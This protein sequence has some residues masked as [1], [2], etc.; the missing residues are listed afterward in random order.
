M[1]YVFDKFL[2]KE[3]KKLVKKYNK[4]LNYWKNNTDCLLRGK[5]KK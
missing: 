2:K 1:N 3:M 5:G 4:A